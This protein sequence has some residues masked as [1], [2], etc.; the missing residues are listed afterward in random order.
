[1]ASRRGHQ[2][3]VPVSARCR[4]WS[5]RPPAPGTSADERQVD[6]AVDEPYVVLDSGTIA[7]WCRRCPWRG[8]PRSVSGLGS[9]DFAAVTAN[10]AAEWQ[11]HACG[12]REREGGWRAGGAAPPPSLIVTEVA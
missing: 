5:A 11:E 9:L 12:A 8:E 3:Q 1:M 6:G 2:R 4:Y 10:S 7:V